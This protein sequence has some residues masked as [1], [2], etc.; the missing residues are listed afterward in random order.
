MHQAANCVASD[1]NL[2]NLRRTSTREIGLVRPWRDSHTLPCVMK[3]M[4]LLFIGRTPYFIHTSFRSIRHSRRNDTLRLELAALRVMKHMNLLFIKELYCYPDLALAHS[5]PSFRFMSITP[6]AT[7]HSLIH[8]AKVASPVATLGLLQLGL[9]LVHIVQ[10]GHIG[11][12]EELQRRLQRDVLLHI[13]RIHMLHSMKGHGFRPS[14]LVFLC[15]CERSL[16]LISILASLAIRGTLILGFRHC[17]AG[18]AELVD[19]VRAL[20]VIARQVLQ[21]LFQLFLDFSNRLEDCELHSDTKVVAIFH[22]RH[23][24][25]NVGFHGLQIRQGLAQ[26]RADHR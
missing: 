26:S 16:F 8:A 14:R 3:H 23:E 13:K 4:N 11:R 15:G 21:F 7:R 2:N 18:Q 10:D 19:R 22:L 25:V 12:N 9:V 5:F 20:A 24:K 1:E 6:V 17:R